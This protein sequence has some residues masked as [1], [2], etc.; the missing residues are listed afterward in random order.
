MGKT[1]QDPVGVLK[2]QMGQ[3][4]RGSIFCKRLS[5]FFFFLLPTSLFP[6]F[7]SS[8]FFL[9][10]IK[11]IINIIVISKFKYLTI[12]A[13]IERVGYTRV[14]LPRWADLMPGK[15]LL[16]SHEN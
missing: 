15:S 10:S 13:T 2:G 4:G 16:A 3:M 6:S 7:L 1:N 14:G 5:Y 11:K 9:P 8:I 12:N